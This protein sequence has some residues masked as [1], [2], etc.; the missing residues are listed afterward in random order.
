MLTCQLEP[1]SM[2]SVTLILFLWEEGAG[3]AGVAGAVTPGDRGLLQH[4]WNMEFLVQ[5]HE[6]LCFSSVAF[7]V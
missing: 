5:H 1:S 6:A 3:E 7:L 2:G 4:C